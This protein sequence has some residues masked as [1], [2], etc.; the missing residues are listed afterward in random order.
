MKQ[1]GVLGRPFYCLKYPGESK[2]M[3]RYVRRMVFYL[4]PLGLF[5]FLCWEMCGADIWALH[6]MV[7]VPGVLDKLDTTVSSRASRVQ[8]NHVLVSYRYM[9]A[10]QQY[11]GEHMVCCGQSNSTTDPILDMRDQLRPLL[12]QRLTVWVDPGNPER[13]VLFRYIS[14]PAVM[15]MGACLLLVFFGLRWYENPRFEQ[16]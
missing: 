2:Q 10:G 8:S 11:R 5:A 13:A 14:K 9:V 12:G 7:P 16:H 4:L 1:K 3:D 15:L 6:R